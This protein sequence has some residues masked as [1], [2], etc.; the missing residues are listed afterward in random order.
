MIVNL[1]LQNK[2]GQDLY[3]NVLTEKINPLSQQIFE[4]SERKLKRLES[5]Q[6]KAVSSTKLSKTT[7]TNSKTG[8][9]YR[10]GRF[11]KKITPFWL[12]EEW[13]NKDLK[14][15]KLNKIKK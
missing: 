9:A 1:H 10:I 11:V 7:Q 2:R 12:T 6:R 5:G 4:P 14:K 3:K 8:F 15:T 13:K